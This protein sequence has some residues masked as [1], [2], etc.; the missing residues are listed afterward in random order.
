MNTTNQNN[1]IETE[2]SNLKDSATMENNASIDFEEYNMFEDIFLSLDFSGK[3]C[4]IMNTYK[5]AQKIASVNITHSGLVFFELINGDMSNDVY[6]DINEY[7]DFLVKL[8]EKIKFAIVTSVTILTHDDDNNYIEIPE[9]EQEIEKEK[10]TK[11]QNANIKMIV[12]WIR[13]NT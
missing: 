8:N 9:E 5:V 2:T 10:Q 12:Q 4:Y 6:T 13:D 1:A 3:T 7:E 11:E